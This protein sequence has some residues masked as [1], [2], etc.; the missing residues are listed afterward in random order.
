MHIPDGYLSAP[1]WATLDGVAAG[2]VSLAVRRVS[3]DMDERKVP[4]M[5]LMAALICAAQMLNFRV[6]GPGLSGHL[7]GSVLVASLLGVGPGILVMTTVLIV[8]A[9]AFGDGGLLAIGANLFNM[10]I[11]GCLL[12][13]MGA[14]IDARRDRGRFRYAGTAIA[15][16]LAVVSAAVLT[17]V[18]LGL[19]RSM[20]MRLILLPMTGFHAII[21]V[22]EAVITVAV[23][24]FLRE[25][26]NALALHQSPAPVTEAKV[27]GES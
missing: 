8:Q 4:L 15:A 23:L 18:E 11:V 10:G 20:D 9:V 3:K 14:A 6:I 25:P 7:V 16:W 27:G 5:G 1:V 21:G 24:R 22:G 13:G 12:G 2:T 26:R 17:S 19:S